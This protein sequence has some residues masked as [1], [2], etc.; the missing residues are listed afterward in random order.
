MQIIITCVAQA[1]TNPGR[2]VTRATKFYTVEPYNGSSVWI[3][4]HVDPL[5]PRN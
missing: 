3:L 5:V 2:H 4:L 1:C